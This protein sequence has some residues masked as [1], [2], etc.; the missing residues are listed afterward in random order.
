MT[1]IKQ[2]NVCPA[3]NST[4]MEMHRTPAT[5]ITCGDCRY[6]LKPWGLGTVDDDKNDLSDLVEGWNE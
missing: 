3:C 2:Y 6:E 1:T 4:N 5:S